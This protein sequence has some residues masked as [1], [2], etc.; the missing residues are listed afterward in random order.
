MAV[1]DSTHETGVIVTRMITLTF[2]M[3]DGDA[4]IYFYSIFL[5]P[6]LGYFLGRLCSRINCQH[7]AISAT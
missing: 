3:L 7:K 1:I 2:G 4:I 5:K 6:C